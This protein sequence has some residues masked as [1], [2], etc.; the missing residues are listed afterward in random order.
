MPEIRIK[1]PLSSSP[2]NFARR[3]RMKAGLGAFT[4]SAS[5]PGFPGPNLFARCR[6]L[7]EFSVPA[8]APGFPGPNLF[9]QFARPAEG[10]GSCTRRCFRRRGLGQDV[11]GGGYDPSNPVLSA[12]FH[13]DPN[14]QVMQSNSIDPLAFPQLS[15]AAYAPIQTLSITNPEME[16]ADASLAPQAVPYNPN[17]S[18]TQNQLLSTLPAAQIV[19]ASNSMQAN[20]AANLTAQLTPA[21]NQTIAAA[22]AKG[23]ITQ[24]QATQLANQVGAANA[25]TPSVLDSLSTWMSKSTLLTGHPNSTVVLGGAAVAV[26]VGALLA[27][28]KGRR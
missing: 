24:A 10:C 5:S 28:K 22:V 4:V 8:S 17:L 20:N 7:G 12:G 21:Q 9:A 27:G 26:L 2:V 25:T 23:T 3:A 19:S 13:L 6:G 11:Y 16:A 15:S 14:Y 18:S 1:I